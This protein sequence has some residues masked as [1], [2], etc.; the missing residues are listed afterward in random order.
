VKR[1][2][3][4]VPPEK[5]YRACEEGNI[6]RIERLI[7]KCADKTILNWSGGTHD[8]TPLW[9][10]CHH[11]HLEVVKRLL[12]EPIIEINKTNSYGMSPLYIACQEGKTEVVKALLAHKLIDPNI[13][14]KDGDRPFD[15]A[16]ARRHLKIANKLLAHKKYNP[17]HINQFGETSFLLACEKGYEELVAFMLARN[18]FDVLH[19]NPQGYNGLHLACQQSK[20][21]VVKRLIKDGRININKQNKIGETPLFLAVTGQSHLMVRYLLDAGADTEITCKDE[22]PWDKV[23]QSYLQSSTPK[24]IAYCKNVIIDMI[25]H[26]LFK[27]SIWNGEIKSKIKA[28]NATRAGIQAIYAG[29]STEIKFCLKEKREKQATMLFALVIFLCDNYLKFK[30]TKSK[31]PSQITKQESDA[32]RFLHILGQLPLDLQEVLCNRTWLQPKSV[33]NPQQ[34]ETAFFETARLI[35]KPK[36][37]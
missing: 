37:K 33:F 27:E 30:A 17:N 3:G 10:A 21:E 11:G 8:A 25:I 35:K 19:E 29:N 14:M 34:K 18:K 9:I 5:F 2:K 32:I 12:K 16:Y 22:S 6:E 1:K 31:K 20:Q 23:Y 28:R 36:T 15:I 24:N 7:S 4:I 13:S 26:F